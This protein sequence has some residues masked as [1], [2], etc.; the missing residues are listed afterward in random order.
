MKEYKLTFH[1]TDGITVT[2]T[3][4]SGLN[5]YD[6]TVDLAKTDRHIVN[7]ARAGKSVIVNMQNCITVEI[8]EA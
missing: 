7:D 1:M 3:A 6:Y 5:K 4:T 8:E 2:T